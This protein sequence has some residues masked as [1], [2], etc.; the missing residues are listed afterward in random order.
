MPV[1]GNVGAVMGQ[2]FI[3]DAHVFILKN[4]LDGAFTFVYVEAPTRYAARRR[5]S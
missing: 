4:S 2:E 5:W 1:A 3:D